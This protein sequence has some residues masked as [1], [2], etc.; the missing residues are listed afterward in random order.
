MYLRNTENIHIIKANI[1]RLYYSSEDQT[2]DVFID[3]FIS[4]GISYYNTYTFYCT[5]LCRVYIIGV[6]ADCQLLLIKIYKR[7]FCT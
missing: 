1:I 2:I 3:I 6:V 7:T 4:M 5:L